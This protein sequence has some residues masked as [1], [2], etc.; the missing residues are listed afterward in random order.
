M[1]RSPKGSL[2]IQDESDMVQGQL[3][4]FSKEHTQR[5]K[6]SAQPEEKTITKIKKQTGAAYS[7]ADIQV[8]EG[9]AAR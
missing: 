9:I 5:E 6:S 7:A 8:L 2:P 4:F 1:S 3:S